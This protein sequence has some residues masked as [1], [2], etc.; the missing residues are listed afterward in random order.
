MYFAHPAVWIHII[1]LFVLRL[2]FKG[3]DQIKL[4]LRKLF[5]TGFCTKADL[6]G[7][8]TQN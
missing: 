8:S 3:L 2:N 4:P 1:L 7:L 5:L 6:P